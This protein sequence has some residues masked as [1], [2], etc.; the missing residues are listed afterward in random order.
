MSFGTDQFQKRRNVARAVSIT[1][2]QR[3]S[4]YKP[5]GL[6]P[7]TD[8]S[9]WRPSLPACSASFASSC[10]L[11]ISLVGER[12]VRYSSRSVRGKRPRHPR[13]P[14]RRHLRSGPDRRRFRA[15]RLTAI[16]AGALQMFDETRVHVDGVKHRVAAHS[17]E[18]A[19][20]DGAPRG[21]PIRK[22]APGRRFRYRYGCLRRP[23]FRSTC[24]SRFRTEL[25]DAR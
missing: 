6:G 25:S 12:G 9:E 18:D 24:G 22:S 13:R 2:D 16:L 11:S 5:V 8:A 14:C 21:P 17:R 7:Q 20:G 15:P 23:C 19:I 10:V 1:R 3:R 4:V